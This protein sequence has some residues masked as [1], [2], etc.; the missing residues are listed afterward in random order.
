MPYIDS[1][2]IR[3]VEWQ[4]GTLSIWFRDGDRYDYDD[5]PERVFKALLSSGSAGAFFQQHIRG[6]Y[7]FRKVRGG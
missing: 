3:R 6:A 2:A 7:A 5:V 1:H 4:G